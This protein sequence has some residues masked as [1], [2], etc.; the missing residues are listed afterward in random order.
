MQTMFEL[1]T[2]FLVPEIKKRKIKKIVGS[3]ISS[4]FKILKQMKAQTIHEIKE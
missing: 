3:F 1:G 2:L 4:F